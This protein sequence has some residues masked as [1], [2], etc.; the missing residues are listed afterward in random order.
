MAPTRIPGDDYPDYAR[1]VGDAVVDG[2]AERG[3]LVCGSG[4]GVA[5][6]A[7]KIPG[8]RASMAH[9]TFSSRQGVEDDDMNVLAL[10]ARV[11]GPELAAELVGA[12]LSARFSGV[13]R[14]V[15]RRRKVLEIER[16]ARA[17]I[18]DP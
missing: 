10:G 2:R 8:V 18:F 17:G 1:I 4:V 11:V 3:I 13:E 14:H 6:A 15:R 5:I 12:F 7:S 16:D 9:D